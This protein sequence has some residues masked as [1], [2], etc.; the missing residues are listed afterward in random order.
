MVQDHAARQPLLPLRNI[1]AS[2]WF[3][4]DL[5]YIQKKTFVQHI[6]H[7]RATING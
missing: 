7:L 2:F 6:E 1:M 3:S 5:T 4:L